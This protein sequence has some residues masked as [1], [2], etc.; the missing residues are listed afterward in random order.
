MNQKQDVFNMEEKA[1]NNRFNLIRAGK[2]ERAFPNL[3]EFAVRAARVAGSQVKR[4]L[5]GRFAPQ[6]VKN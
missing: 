2:S 3:N 5:E 6:N 4:M 1:S